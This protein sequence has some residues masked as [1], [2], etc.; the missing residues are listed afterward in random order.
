MDVF[1]A[2]AEPTRRSIVELLSRNGSMSSGEI[3]NRFHVTAPAISQHLKVLREANLVRVEKRAQQ[4]IYSV[5]PEAIRVLS[6]W[7]EQV[8]RRFDR[9]AA[10]LK[11]DEEKS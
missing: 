10:L 5:N 11:A 2:L 9:L 1:S 8:N 6:R 7:A 3:H 4:R